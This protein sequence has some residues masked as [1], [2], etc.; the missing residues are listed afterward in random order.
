MLKKW[1]TTNS[2]DRWISN[3]LIIYPYYIVS[4]FLIQNLNR[5][6]II[7]IE[8]RKKTSSMFD[9]YD[10]GDGKLWKKRGKIKH[11]S[12][13]NITFESIIIN[14]NNNNNHNNDD[15]DDD[16]ILIVFDV[17]IFYFLVNQTIHNWL[18]TNVY[19]MF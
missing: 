18:Y 16:I 15:D 2:S 5:V 17:D 10:H 13:Y 3:I 12:R 11:F 14:N 1:D 8:F 9:C 7:F 4:I 6:I 19:A